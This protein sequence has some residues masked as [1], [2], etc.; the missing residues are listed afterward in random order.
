MDIN[1]YIDKV[2]TYKTRVS[3]RYYSI[4]ANNV[5]EGIAKQEQYFVS[6]KYDGHMFMM[7]YEKGEDVVFVN[8]KGKQVKDLHIN[9]KA[10]EILDGQADIQQLAV[11]GEMYVSGGYEKKRTR[12]FDFTKA[13]TDKNENI[14]FAVFDTVNVNNES[15]QNKSLEEI[16]DQL[17]KIFPE[18]GE[19]HLAKNER[20]TSRNNIAELFKQK[21]EIEQ[22]EGI[23]VK[24]EGQI[25]K[26]KPKYTFDAVVIGF[27]DS[28]GERQGMFRDLLIAMMLPDNSYQILGH[29]HHGFSDDERKALLEEMILEIVPSEYI[30]VAR[31]KTAFH[32]IKP[33][34]VIEFSCL[35]VI[36]EDSNQAIAKMNLHYT[37]EEGYTLNGKKNSVSL[38]IP[39]FVRFR[40]DK[41]PNAQDVRFEQL[42]EVIS[43]DEV[44][45]VDEKDLEPGEIIRREAYYKVMKENTMVRKFVIIKTNKENTG[46]FPAYVVYTSDFSAGRAEP[47]KRDLKL[48]NSDSQANELF[49]KAL[50]KNVTKGWIKAE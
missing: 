42:K 47:L 41:E 19:V 15:V 10:K 6:T 13:L 23:V 3:S 11:A 29:L 28:D 4:D 12:S 25:Y 30:E 18:S 2:K 44:D 24:T 27:A 50:E 48:T 45:V 8:P 38:T 33:T 46:K 5:T 37:E 26:V 22:Q 34:R 16:V 43:F 40:T 1:T 39:T 32:M 31:N 36:T 35:D 14:R 49:D 21:V 20:V 7:C 17:E 9:K